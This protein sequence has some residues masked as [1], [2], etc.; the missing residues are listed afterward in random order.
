MKPANY[1]SEAIAFISAVKISS[2]IFTPHLAIHDGSI[3][4]S[5][6]YWDFGY[7]AQLIQSFVFGN[8]FPPQIPAFSGVPLAYHFMPMLHTAVY[9]AL[10]LDLVGSMN[11]V[12]IVNF[13]MLL[14]AII[15][16]AEE[17]FGSKI[18]GLFAI[19]LTLT[20]SSFH[21][22]ELSE[23]HRS[24]IGLFE[25]ALSFTN[26]P[27][28]AGF[29]SNWSHSYNGNMFNLF[30][31]IAERQ[32]IIGCC[33]ILIGLAFIL[34]LQALSRATCLFVGAA[35]G[36]LA[37]W[38][39][40]ITVALGATLSGI[41]LFDRH[42]RKSAANMLL[43]FLPVCALLLKHY[44]RLSQNEW[45]R[46][47]LLGQ[48]PSINLNFATW[49]EPTT[50]SLNNT[51]FYW[52]YGYGV[53]LVVLVVGLMLLR[54][55]SDTTE[56]VGGSDRKLGIAGA[57]VFTPIVIF[58]IT[59]FALINLVQLSPIS[60]YDNHKWLRPMN[61]VVD[62]CCGL[63]LWH[64]ASTGSNLR[65]L[66][67]L[68]LVLPLSAAGLME[69]T[70]LLSTTP[71]IF[72]SRYPTPTI[73]AIRT[74]SSAGDVFLTEHSFPILLA[75]RKVFMRQGEAPRGPALASEDLVDSLR[76]FR[77][78]YAIYNSRELQT[79]CRRIKEAGITYIEEQ[80]ERP[81]AII[82][83][84]LKVKVPFFDVTN[85]Q[86]QPVRFLNAQWACQW[87]RT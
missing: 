10:G 3:Y 69:N 61:L 36:L 34:S 5:P 80:Q 12:S 43:G 48:F 40:F 30:Y 4:T 38:H 84:E 17:W 49:S 44:S 19:G 70:A 59:S 20:S 45:Y 74:N 23:G 64:L 47:D 31:F 9:A 28:L 67:V 54:R 33:A 18:A 63:A 68:L 60:I 52:I 73:Q 51:I 2:I 58:L 35:F 27:Y 42:R 72:Y 65:R 66:V 46:Q 55:V 86:G 22:L 37:D 13:A 11:F 14:L 57:S 76:R 50:F 71:I 21:F 81:L 1:F 53:K 24:V 75:G 79:L 16:C 6:V 41:V 15:G 8:N 62:L 29:S 7:Q 78:S 85:E 25:Y 77:R 87:S 83:E 26:D 39:L 82:P 56:G 32:L